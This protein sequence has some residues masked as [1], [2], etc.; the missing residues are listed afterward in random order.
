M[1]NWDNLQDL[2]NFLDTKSRHSREH[3]LAVKFREKKSQITQ[4]LKRLPWTLWMQIQEATGSGKN[5]LF[6][7]G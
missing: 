6:S 2:I 7:F 3:Q 1:N 5:N 4:I